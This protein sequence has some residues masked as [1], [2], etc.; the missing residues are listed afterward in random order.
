M[1][2]NRTKRAVALSVERLEDRLTPTAAVPLS[3]S[4]DST[5]LGQLPA[6]WAQWSSTGQPVFG[7]TNALANSPGQS[8]AATTTRDWVTASAWSTTAEPADVE[9]SASVYLHSNMPLLL[10][11][12]GSN[13]NGLSGTYYG[14]QV[15]PSLWLKVIRVQNGVGT[16]V[17]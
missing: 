9:I 6:G 12:R 1:P 2:D 16:T 3:E 5:A 15:M 11:A 10:V 14:L 4:F 8:L 7:A 13:L 17:G